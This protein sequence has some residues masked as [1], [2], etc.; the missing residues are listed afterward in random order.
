MPLANDTVRLSRL[1]T[2]STSAA[3]ARDRR[4]MS[5]PS[6]IASTCE[7]VVR[8]L[9]ASYAPRDFG[10]ESLDFQV[11]VAEDFA[12]PMDR[13]VSLFLYKVARDGVPRQPP[14]RVH[15]DGRIERTRLPVDL[16][17]L[18]TAWA[19]HASLQHE[20]AGWMMRVIED[21]SLLTPPLLNGYRADVF[22]ADETVE[23]IPAEMTVEDL[24]RIWETL[25]SHTYQL[26]VPYVART[27]H[28]DSVLPQTRGEPVQE[29]VFPI[30]DVGV[31][32]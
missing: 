18:L 12:N 32:S 10:G 9:R 15:R 1:T 3:A 14:G 28:L 19:K 13:G 20:I 29:R 26:S 2:V 5:R 17:F 11:Y 8:L 27:L 7:A 24:F 30:H 21:S 31:E 23:L 25:V 4:P 6:A 16:Y 22:A